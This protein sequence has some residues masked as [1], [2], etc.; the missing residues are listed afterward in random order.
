MNFLKWLFQGRSI[1][2]TLP[3]LGEKNLGNPK[4]PENQTQHEF[5]QEFLREQDRKKKEGK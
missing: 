4:E 2:I 1:R 5:N 3:W